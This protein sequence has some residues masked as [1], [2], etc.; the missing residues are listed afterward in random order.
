MNETYN[1]VPPVVPPSSLSP[2]PPK[3]GN[4]QAIAS[5]VLGILSFVLCGPLFAV[6]AI[7]L[8]HM[9]L[10]KIRRGV[11][12]A[13]SRGFALA[14]TILGWVNLG[15]FLLFSTAYILWISLSAGHVSPFVYKL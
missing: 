9:T 4:G 3:E 14:G 7:I 15:L 10:G 1:P 6:P 12:P 2:Q 8:G 11:M 5:M 13:D